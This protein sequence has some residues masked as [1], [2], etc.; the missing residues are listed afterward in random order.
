[1]L[2]TELPEMISVVNKVYHLQ[3][4]DSFLGDIFMITDSEPFYSL[5]SGL[6]KLFSYS[7]LNYKIVHSNHSYQFLVSILYYI[8]VEFSEVISQVAKFVWKLA[9]IW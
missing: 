7:Q 8:T 2:L 3:Y 5:T 6:N 9:S 1:M 4:S